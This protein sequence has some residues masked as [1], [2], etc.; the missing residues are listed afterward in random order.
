MIGSLFRRPRAVSLPSPRRISVALVLLLLPGA[1]LALGNGKLQVHHM[2]VGQGDGILLIS[3]QGQTALFDTG[4]SGCSFIKSYLQGLGITQVDY[5]FLSHYH[6]DHLSCMDDL[7]AAGIT[8]GTAG[9]D[10]GYSYSSSAYTNY[11]NTLGSKRKTISKG[12][13]ITL[14]AGSSN[15]VSI[16]CV[17]LN[18]AGKYS[19]TGS[20]ENPK[21]VVYK[22][23]YGQFDEVIGGDLTGSSGSKDVESVIGPQVGDVEVYKVHHHGS[24]YSTNDNWLSATQPEVA[25]IQV[26]NNSYGH[27]TAEALGRLHNYGVKTYWTETGSGVA[28]N[29]T[30]DKVGGTIV[31]E[32]DPGAG[33]TYTVKGN[34]FTHTYTNSGGAFAAGLVAEEEWATEPAAEE[35]VRVAQA[36]P[37]PAS[38]VQPRALVQQYAARALRA[39]VEIVW[40]TAEDAHVD[41]FEVYREGATGEPVLLKD[42]PVVEV[43]G[44]VARYRVVDTSPGAATYW[45]AARSCEGGEGFIGPIHVPAAR[46][47]R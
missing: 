44:T 46:A 1:A 40:T 41:G 4:T 21:S 13:V 6:A 17:D 29:S 26:G 20:D 10:R 31:V 32:A 43:E 19:A 18:G 2:Q 45:L 28:P 11:V 7:A 37:V 38:L 35:P 14:D 36:Q 9:Y 34:G 3:P 27:P 23:S 39:G 22:V 12:Q 5:H 42:E 33:A 47:G 30:W 16:K 8:I 24:K 15:P 25:I